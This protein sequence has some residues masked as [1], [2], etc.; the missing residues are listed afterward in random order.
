MSDPS[1]AV[2][3]LTL[4][5]E[6]GVD[7]ETLIKCCRELEIPIADSTAD[8]ISRDCRDSLVQYVEEQVTST[9]IE[10]PATAATSANTSKDSIEPQ[11]SQPAG[12][13]SIWGHEPASI[14][15]S[16]DEL[17][18]LLS[19]IPRLSGLGISVVLPDDNGESDEASGV[20]RRLRSRS[21][22]QTSTSLFSADRLLEFDWELALDGVP[23]SEEELRQLAEL[24]RPFIRL[25]GKWVFLDSGM[26]TPEQIQELVSEI[27]SGK[28]F[29]ITERDLLSARLGLPTDRRVS[30]LD[31]SSLPT[32]M[33]SWLFDS[34]D[35]EERIPEG[36]DATLRGYQKTGFSWLVALSRIGV[37][38]CL[39]DDMGLGK[40][41]QTLAWLQWVKESDDS[42][43]SLLVCPTS[44]LRN[45]Q[46]E[47]QKFSPSLRVYE[48][49]GSKRLSNAVDIF[50]EAR[51]HDVIITTYGTLTRDVKLFAK[52]E[53][54]ALILDEAQNIKNADSQQSLAARLLAPDA[55]FRIALTGT[56]IENRAEELWTLMDFLNPSLFGT[57]SRFT[58]DFQ[59]PIDEGSVEA[60]NRL[61]N[62]TQPFLLRRSKQDKDLLPDLPD[63]FESTVWCSL[64]VSQGAA[65][66]AILDELQESLSGGASSNRSTTVL[67][68]LTR[69]KQVCDHPQL[70]ELQDDGPD[71]A[72]VEFTEQ[73]GKLT[74]L[75]EMLEEVIAKDEKALIFTQYARMGAIL[76]DHLLERLGRGTLFLS[77]KDDADKRDAKVQQFQ[78]DPRFPFFIL[79]TKAGGTGL[80]LT[81]ANHVF[82]FDRWWNPA[83]EDQATDRAH[84]IGQELDVNVYKFVCQGTL[85][86]QIDELITR[87]KKL[88]SDL[89]QSVGDK[90]LGSILSSF[91]DGAPQEFLSLSQLAVCE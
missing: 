34:Q 83:V 62:A 2:Q 82:H 80:N 52:T 41:I 28:S 68:T 63:K 55:G 39:A 22:Q 31:S 38:C 20:T 17:C 11:P 59:T 91:D 27:Q 23:L 72:T 15:V 71:Q 7:C 75:V 47:V 79:T 40:T 53:W 44:L 84:R 1:D 30:G 51:N 43:C 74:R 58:T 14:K 76:E 88:S 48:H 6:L 50:G 49:H 54:R 5:T 61:R 60:T 13:S 19:G 85:E 69:L 65:Y 25:R 42:K 57:R 36:L 56:P 10:R 90:G 87:K 29:K 9:P 16:S 66:R 32:E 8:S 24:K 26:Q 33:F 77:G 73:S 89:L 64:T 37:G 3:I 81:K 70:V 35:A 78:N 12:L 46:R 4:A 21:E 18:R 86:E 45:W 67:T